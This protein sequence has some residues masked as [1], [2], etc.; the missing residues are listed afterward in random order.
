MASPVK[1]ALV[2]DRISRL[3]KTTM[4]NMFATLP[5]MQTAQLR[6]PWMELYLRVRKIFHYEIMRKCSWTERKNMR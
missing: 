2:G 4:F 5:N 3:V 1:I 6:Y